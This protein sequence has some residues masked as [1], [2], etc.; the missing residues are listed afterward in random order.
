MVSQMIAD[1]IKIPVP[2]IDKEIQHIADML[3]ATLDMRDN[4]TGQHSRNVAIYAYAMGTALGLSEQEL[5]DL[6]IAGIFHDVGKFGIAEN[7]LFKPDKLTQEELELVRTHSKRSADIVRTIEAIKDLAFVVECHHERYDGEGYPHRLKGESIPLMSRIIA[8]ADA[9][10]AMT[11]D[12]C[13]KKPKCL[14]DAVNE[15]RSMVFSQFDPAVVE[16]FI[17]WLVCQNFIQDSNS[18]KSSAQNFMV[19]FVKTETADVK[20]QNGVAWVQGGKIFVRDPK[21]GYH[22]AKIF[23][24]QGVQIQINGIEIQQAIEI[25]ANDCIRIEPITHQEPGYVKVH[26]SQDKLYAFLEM[27][28]HISR[29]YELEDQ[30]PATS[31]KLTVRQTT[32]NTAPLTFDEILKLL[33]KNQIHYGIDYKVIKQ[34][35]DYPYEGTVEV[36]RG[37]APTTPVNGS[38]ELFFDEKA[39]NYLSADNHVSI[40]FKEINKLPTVG[41][42]EALALNHLPVQG[43]PGKSVTGEVI[44]PEAPLI[45]TLFA[46]KGVQLVENGTKAVALEEGLPKVKKVGVNWTLSVDSVLLHNGDVN[47]GTGNIRFRGGVHILG[48]VDNGM[49]V[50]ATGDVVVASLVTG[51]K[52]TAGSNIIVK[53]N[54]VNGE[55]VAGGFVILAKAIQPLLAQLCLYLQEVYRFAEASF[56]RIAPTS[57]VRLGNILAFMK[58]RNFNRQLTYAETLQKKLKEYDLKLLG[59]YEEQLT[60]ALNRLCGINLMNFDTPQDFK[61][62]LDT[63][64]NVINSLTSQNVLQGDV[65]I[66]CALNSSIS[67]PG[68]VSVKGPGCFNTEIVTD[69]SVV[70]SGVFRGGN[71]CAGDHSQV[72]EAGSEMGSKTMISVPV[73]KH[74]KLD[75]IYPGVILQIGKRIKTIDDKL[76]RVEFYLDE[77]GDIRMLNY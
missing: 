20:T 66:T 5:K 26:F 12:R 53:G 15:L 6:Y 62:V 36:A 74:I 38:V 28:P 35:V 54:V 18:K 72:C 21:P 40:D 51:A 61:T 68:P 71:I 63:I 45:F 10:D 64:E 39:R 56:N 14:A 9:F 46:G 76:T 55:L 2:E 52:V 60:Q 30:Q 4:T 23:P 44:E 47:M 59:T 73:D 58:E 1:Q 29:S 7:V 31:L 65:K 13:Y 49:S 11:M 22:K 77:E 27:K 33:Q 32:V 25:S 43:Q 69:S 70:V 34:L 17:N 16:I 42:G 24:C 75:R 19:A 41:C 67:S 3:L 8:V 37:Q 50:S 57:P 48:C